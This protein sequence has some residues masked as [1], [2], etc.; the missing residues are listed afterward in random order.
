MHFPDQDF[1][2][3]GVPGPLS[4]AM[5]NDV[6]GIEESAV[7]WTANPLKVVIP[8]NG[9]EGNVLKKQD[10]IIY[11]DDHYFKLF[12]YEWLAGSAN[13]IL[14]D[15]NKVVLT[16]SRARTYFPFANPA[17][18]IGQIITYDDS[19]KATVTGIVKD[20]DETTDLIFKEFIS[21][22]TFSENLKK[23]NGW[24]SWGSVTSHSQFFIKLQKGIDEKKINVA[25]ADLRKRH[26]KNDYLATDH[27]LQSLTD[28]H[29]NADFDAFDHRQAHKPTL[30]GLLA[31]AAF[32]LLLGCINF[33]NLTTAQA[34]QRAKEIG[35]RK[36][37]GSS[38][39][40]L[41]LQFLS[42][43][44][45]LTF[46]ATILSIVLTPSIIKLFSAFIP[47]GLKF[48]I[49][50]QPNV[51]IF[52][53]ILILTVGL[54]SGFYP[55]LILSGYKPVIVLKN[56]AFTNSLKAVVYGYVKH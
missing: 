56:L 32:L 42:E 28:I 31:V 41:V 8:Q 49:F 29:F 43:T 55:A 6:T 44:F 7:F 12:P 21:L 11:A 39:L 37:M 13:S 50:N 33:I 24:D 47:E 20:L 4:T 27:F 46:I 52:I 3:G 30:Y 9:G 15:P 53:L 38:R 2:N 45:L 35:I 10:H 54:L 25:L 1:K 18:A 26:S 36:T 14:N 34:A 5:R 40:H 19:V 51:I 48:A 17:Q 23:N 16:E 22:S